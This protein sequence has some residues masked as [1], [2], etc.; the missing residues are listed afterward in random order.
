MKKMKRVIALFLCLLM[1]SS[2][3]PISVFAEGEVPGDEPAV[4]C[5][6]CNQDPCTC[7]SVVELSLYEQL[8]AAESVADLNA[9][10]QAADEETCNA[11]TADEIDAL[12]TRIDTLDPEGDDADTDALVDLLIA[13]PG[14]TSGAEQDGEEAAEF[15]YPSSG[16]V[17]GRTITSN[18]VWNLTGDMTLTGT[19]VI[20]NGVKFKL[21][22]SLSFV[23]C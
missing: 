23:I 15:A 21:C 4:V 3:A 8:L 16:T 17:S 13:L 9:L 5:E 19:I 1:L 2:L 18:Q 20:P 14:F 22:K 12:L 10:L 7:E 6:T 11:L